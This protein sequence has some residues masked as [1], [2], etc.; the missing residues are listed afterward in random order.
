MPHRTRSTAILP[1]I[2]TFWYTTSATFKLRPRVNKM[3]MQRKQKGL[4]LFLVGLLVLPTIFLMSIYLGSS[5]AQKNL[6]NGSI[7]FPKPS[8]EIK[9]PNSSILAVS[10]GSSADGQYSLSILQSLP[11]RFFLDDRGFNNSINLPVGV[12]VKISV[13]GQTYNLE[14]LSELFNSGKVPTNSSNP[15]IP[16]AASSVMMVNY[17]VETSSTVPPGQYMVTIDCLSFPR[18]SQFASLPR[19]QVLPLPLQ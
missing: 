1:K 9:G 5:P 14:S 2:S 16:T 13:N 11:I 19:I 6:P 18:P 17:E 10:R 15:V 7:S 8:V 4:I 12:T 3:K